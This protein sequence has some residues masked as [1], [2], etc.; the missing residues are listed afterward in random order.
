MKQ[1]KPVCALAV[2]LCMMAAMT[3]G[4]G[5]SG[6]SP[7]SSTG[8]SD[9][10]NTGNTQAPNYFP[11]A[12]G[13]RWIY[14]INNGSSTTTSEITQGDVNVFSMKSVNTASAAYTVYDGGLY[15]NALSY[16]KATTYTASGGVAS[17]TSWSPPLVIF[18]S[19]TDIS[20][21]E[22]YTMTGRTREITVSGAETVTVPAG[23]FMNA[24]KVVY[25]DTITSGTT[26]FISSAT[27]WYADGVGL[28]KST[29]SGYLQELERYEHL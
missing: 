25:K 27:I 11:I 21:H 6:G 12:T 15:N 24:L 26:T 20:T 7:T 16:T 2:F 9:P 10:G 4:C 1:I 5:G 3:T 19:R 23:T 14:R 29:S 18:P 13:N 22:T 28:I 17:V 8:N